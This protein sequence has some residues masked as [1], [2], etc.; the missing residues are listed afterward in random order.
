MR[1]AIAIVLGLLATL[2]G[3]SIPADVTR[4]AD[5]KPYFLV[6]SPEM[7]DPVFRNSVIMMV[8]TIQAPLLAGVIVNEPTGTSAHEDVPAFFRRSGRTSL[9]SAYYGGPID[10]GTPRRSRS[11]NIASAR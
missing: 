4:A 2:I 8:P 11:T 6:A 5:T 7:G 1:R 3:L 9:N 10:N